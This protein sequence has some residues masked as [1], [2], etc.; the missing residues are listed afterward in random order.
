M[1][2]QTTLDFGESHV[3]L[4]NMTLS[5][6]VNRTANTAANEIILNDSLHTHIYHELFVCGKGTLTLQT[7][8]GS[9]QLDAGDAALVPVGIRHV[10]K[11]IPMPADYEVIGF[12][13]TP[14]NG[15]PLSELYK[16]LRPLQN[17]SGILIFR[18]APTLF[19]QMQEVIVGQSEK[20]KPDCYPALKMLMLL[21]D[22]SRLPPEEERPLLQ[23]SASAPRSKDIQ[24]IHVLEQMIGFQYVKP[25]RLSDFA[26]QLHIGSRQLERIVYQH[27]GKSLRRVIME[28]RL[29]A[30]EKLLLYSDMTIDKIAFSVGFGSK[31]GF[32]REF[33][34]R[35]KITPVQFRNSE[36]NHQK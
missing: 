11:E 2:M 16:S 10:L 17:A 33:Q 30:A 18:H 25:F 7:A 6:I 29:Q 4:E 14:V 13:C 21:L 1:K 24:F 32:Y 31:A 22:L 12:L 5:V 28:E 36:Q 8:N 34:R 35:H 23:P 9:L 20:E 19:G 3:Q 26:E 27:Y 15:Q